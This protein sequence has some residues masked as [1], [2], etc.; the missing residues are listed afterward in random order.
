MLK[1]AVG[2]LGDGAALRTRFPSPTDNDAL[3]PFRDPHGERDADTGGQRDPPVGG[4][5]GDQIAAH[6]HAGVKNFS[7]DLAQSLDAQID[8]A[9]HFVQQVALVFC[10]ERGQIAPHDAVVQH[11]PHGRGGAVGEQ[12]HAVAL[13]R[14]RPLNDEDS[15]AEDD[16]LP[17]N[18]GQTGAV[19][20]GIEQFAL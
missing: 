4:Q 18:G 16:R 7:D 8:V 12:P 5:H 19:N 9:H 1:V 2:L 14:A 10:G 3:E 15:R 20:D 11:P 17:Q 13:G 6:E